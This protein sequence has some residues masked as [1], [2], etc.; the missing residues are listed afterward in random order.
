MGYPKTLYGYCSARRPCVW[1]RPIVSGAAVSS[2]AFASGFLQIP[3]LGGQPC[4]WLIYFILNSVF[5]TFSLEFIYMPDIHSKKQVASCNPLFPLF[6]GQPDRR[7]FSL[8]NTNVIYLQLL[9]KDAVINPFLSSPSS[10]NGEVQDQI[11]VVI[12]RPFVER[13][14]RV[15][16]VQVPG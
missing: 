10:A 8:V 4:P 14:M 15:G 7:L 13:L 9:R 12:K 6:Q 16:K 1:G 11:T 5:R 3:P 2:G